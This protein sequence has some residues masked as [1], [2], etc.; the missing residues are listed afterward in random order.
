MPLFQPE[1]KILLNGKHA[2]VKA[3]KDIRGGHFEIGV[4]IPKTKNSTQ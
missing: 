1:D 2:E 3:L 4:F